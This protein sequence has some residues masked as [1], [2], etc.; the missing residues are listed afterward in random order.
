MFSNKKFQI[1]GQS[2]GI[3]QLAFYVLISIYAIVVV[4]TFTDYGITIDEPPHAR[5]GRDIVIWYLSF[6]KEDAFLN[7]ENMLFYGGLFDTIIHPITQISPLDIH[8]TR[9]LCN[10]LVGLLGIIST[11]K[12]GV[13]LGTPATGLLAA[14]FLIF[15]PRYY[16]HAFNNPK[17]IPF[18]VGYIWSLYYLVKSLK[19][20][21]LL[22]KN[23]LWKLAIAIG[24]TMAVRVGGAILLIYVGLFFCFRYVRVVLLQNKSEL[25]ENVWF[26]PFIMQTVTIGITSYLIMLLFWPRALIDPFVYPLHVLRVFSHFSY[27]VTT[28]FEGKEITWIEIPWYYVPKWMS[29]IL[30]EFVFLGVLAGIIWLILHRR[31]LALNESFLQWSLVVF[32][33]LFP[34]VYVVI[35]HSPLGDALRHFLFIY[36]PIAIIAAT[37]TEALVRHCQSPGL[38]WSF[39]GIMG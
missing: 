21:P 2:F 23:T 39:I 5:Y 36:P 15:M 20:L 8:D 34:P 28:F 30:P 9:H 26:R 16:G 3:Y 14:I 10:A 27:Y 38:R 11:Y 35:I 24:L 25:S 37:G 4:C 32:A 12:L 33:A 29:M 1:F 6:F 18:A 22:S 31:Q 13:C 19:E 17:D 7:A